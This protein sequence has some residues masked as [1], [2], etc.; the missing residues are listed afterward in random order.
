MVDTGTSDTSKLNSDAAWEQVWQELRRVGIFEGQG[1]KA[2]LAIRGLQLANLG[3]NAVS[4]VGLLVQSVM[5]AAERHTKA[6]VRT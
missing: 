1:T 2:E 3:A 5:Q 6:D 4:Y